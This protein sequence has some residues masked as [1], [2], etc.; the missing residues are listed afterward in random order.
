MMAN[1][2]FPTKDIEELLQQVNDGTPPGYHS[3]K[4]EI[5][6]EYLKHRSAKYTMKEEIESGTFPNGE[7]GSH[8][9][10]LPNQKQGGFLDGYMEKLA[11]TDIERESC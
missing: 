10:C 2:P 9:L 1:L 11:S 4:E 6:Q 8:S 7:G 5:L 3:D